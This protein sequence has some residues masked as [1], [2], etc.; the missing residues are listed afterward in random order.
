[1]SKKSYI[2]RRRRKKLLL[3]L[4]PQPRRPHQLHIRTKAQDVAHQFPVV[5]I[6][7]GQHQ[8]AI[9]FSL[10]L[11]LRVQTSLATQRTRSGVNLRAAQALAAPLKMP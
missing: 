9:R 7:K 1:M 3:H 10:G 4:A 5:R 6:R 2:P 8:A 11:L